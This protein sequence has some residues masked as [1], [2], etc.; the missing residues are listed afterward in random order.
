MSNICITSVCNRNC[1]YC[2]SQ[3]DT[4]APAFMSLDLFRQCLAFLQRSE[5][6]QVRILGG[7]PTLHPN[8][9]EI[10]D[11]AM[12]TGKKI[13]LFTNGMMPEKT[14]DFL[15]ELPPEKLTVM[16][17]V[18]PRH[19]TRASERT[20]Q[21][22]VL[23][24]LGSR[25]KLSFTIYSPDLQLNELCDLVNEAS[26]VRRVRLG[27]ALPCV[28]E[29]NEWLHPRYYAHVGEKIV[30]FALGAARQHVFVGLDCGFVPCMFG[31]EGMEQLKDCHA[32][33]NWNCSPI[34]DIDTSGKVFY[35]FPLAQRM[36]AVMEH[37]DDASQ[38]RKRFG[39]QGAPYSRAGIFKE[40]CRCEWKLAGVCPGG[41]L[42]AT[43]LRFRRPNEEQQ[44]GGYHA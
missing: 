27:L 36:S 31:K 39:E 16:M 8:F 32:N 21:R 33:V 34:L 26:T 6:D 4:G 20:R 29:S 43:I 2:F 40:C 11:L 25:A 19:G 17:N 13:L 35:C 14:L 5:I 41:C 23:Q 42:A 15:S 37:D 44:D 38:L 12:E 3:H 9:R 7:E 30:E 28:G 18:T 22:S 1:D 10:M 24:R